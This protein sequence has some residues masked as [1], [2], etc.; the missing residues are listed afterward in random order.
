MKY[1]RSL[2][3]ITLLILAFTLPVSAD[4]CGDVSCPGIAPPSPVV[5]VNGETPCGVAEIAVSLIQSMLSL[6]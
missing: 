6:S 2:C 5:T 1:A 4:T 3:A